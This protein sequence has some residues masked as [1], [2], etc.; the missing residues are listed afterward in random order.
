[1]KEERSWD[2]GKRNFPRKFTKGEGSKN[3]GRATAEKGGRR[4]WGRKTVKKRKE[5][6]C[7]PRV[8]ERQGS[9]R[10]RLNLEW[11]E[12]G[13]DRSTDQVLKHGNV[14]TQTGGGAILRTTGG[15]AV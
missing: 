11:G 9:L 8:N 6:M 15:L 14:K 2:K 13:Q 10:A 1:M 4:P 5:S 12:K 3:R 7:S